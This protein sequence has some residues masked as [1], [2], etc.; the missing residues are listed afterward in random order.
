MKKLASIFLAT[1]LLGCADQGPAP[2]T[3][4]SARRA[5]SMAELRARSRSAGKDAPAGPMR[6]RVDVYHLQ[7]PFGTV[8]RRDDF[9]KNVDEQCV[10]PATHDLLY[11][12][13]LRVGHAPVAEWEQ[14]K[15]LI[16]EDSAKF[17]ASSILGPE[18]RNV[19]LNVRK[20]VETQDIWYINGTGGLQG[21]TYD[22][23][24]NYWTVSFV[25][26]P[27]KPGS[28]RVGLCPVV[29]TMRQRLE[30]TEKGN[31]REIT[32]TSPERIYDVNLRTDIPPGHFM[33]VAPSEEAAWP[34]SIGSSFLLHD[35]PT[36]RVESVLLFA[37]NQA[38][39][40]IPA[41]E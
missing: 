22:R 31:E 2:A 24:E 27:R 6:I 41:N 15:Q 30:V 18:A 7:V 4:P 23:C 8:S 5:Q 28:V 13:G 38:S 10:D 3:Q 40:P 36:E 16:S 34:T 39:L 35:G 29:K 25:P 26:A 14:F 12:N 11:R 19:D 33:I 9:W 1:A 32:Y 20:Q 37:P 17:Q 21:C